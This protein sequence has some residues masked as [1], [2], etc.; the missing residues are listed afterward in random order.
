MSVCVCVYV[1]M[2]MCVCVYVYVCMRV[3]LCVYVCTS[4]AFVDLISFH[5]AMS[6][7]TILFESVLTTLPPL[8]SYF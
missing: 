3:C 4:V 5:V 6:L 7:T 8:A 2:C 1:C